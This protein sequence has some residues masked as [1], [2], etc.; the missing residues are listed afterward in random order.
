MP[1][2][3]K[4]STITPYW[5]VRMSDGEHTYVGYGKTYDDVWAQ[6]AQVEDF[7][8]RSTT[9]QIY[10][11]MVSC[12]LQSGKGLE[13]HSYWLEREARD[14]EDDLGLREQ[15]MKYSFTAKEVL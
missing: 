14:G 13:N 7:E 11:R 8:V 15:M 2:T 10:E 4:V 5:M 9:C 3:Q 12:P 6:V 1:T